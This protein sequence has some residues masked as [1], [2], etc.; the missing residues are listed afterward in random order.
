LA[1]DRASG[2]PLTTPL[3]SVIPPARPSPPPWL[4]NR[5]RCPTAS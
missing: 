1:L 3:D 4:P 5:R 2:A